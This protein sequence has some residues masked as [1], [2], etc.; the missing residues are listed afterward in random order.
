MFSD[1][2]IRCSQSSTTFEVDT[3]APSSQPP[4][5]GTSQETPLDLTA[6]DSSAAHAPAAAVQGPDTDAAPSAAHDVALAAFQL[7]RVRGLGAAA[8]RCM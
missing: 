5:Q 8:N 3:T 6:A 7:L 1:H 2:S 4:G